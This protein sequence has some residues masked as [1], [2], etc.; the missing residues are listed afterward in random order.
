MEMCL[1]TG[2]MVSETFYLHSHRHTHTHTHALYTLH[3]LLC[4]LAD[5]L[6]S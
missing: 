1:L 2:R 5:I 6:S 3:I 4:S